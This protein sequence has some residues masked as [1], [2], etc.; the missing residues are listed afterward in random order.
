[1]RIR[2]GGAELRRLTTGPDGSRALLQ[3]S[4]PFS[5]AWLAG[6][7]E[8]VFLVVKKRK[9]K[10]GAAKDGM[11]GFLDS[12]LDSWTDTRH[13]HTHPMERKRYGGSEK[14]SISSQRP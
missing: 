13:Q 2:V 14:P 5:I 10:C 9:G 4:L 6:A 7:S 1:M 8:P 3:S 11:D 12:F